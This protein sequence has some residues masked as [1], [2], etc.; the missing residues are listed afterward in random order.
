M[1]KLTACV[2]HTLD[3]NQTLLANLGAGLI[4]KRVPSLVE[5]MDAWREKS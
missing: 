4:V 5:L 2:Y 3:I 1:G